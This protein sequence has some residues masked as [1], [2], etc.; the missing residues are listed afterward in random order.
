MENTEGSLVL[1]IASPAEPIQ[2]DVVSGEVGPRHFGSWM[3]LV[4]LIER[5]RAEQGGVG[6][7]EEPDPTKA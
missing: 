2:G 7:N 4:A 5:W 6:H 1:R 3:E